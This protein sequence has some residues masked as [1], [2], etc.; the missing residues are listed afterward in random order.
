MSHAGQERPTSV[1]QVC[2]HIFIDNPILNEYV[3]C[4]YSKSFD[5]FSWIFV[6]GK[7][8]RWMATKEINE[9]K[10]WMLKL[11][12]VRSSQVR[13]R[14]STEWSVRAL[15]GRDRWSHCHSHSNS[16]F[17]SMRWSRATVQLSTIVLS[18]MLATP[19]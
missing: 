18:V 19:I 11:S 7:V 14:S 1:S 16:H 5:R 4:E 13:I 2:N 12:V 17:C 15:T 6:Y 9:I 3:E 10:T 8:L